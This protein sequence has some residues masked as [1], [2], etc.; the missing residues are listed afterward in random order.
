MMLIKR[1]VTR[2]QKNFPATAIDNNAKMEN[3][4][5]ANTRSSGIKNNYCGMKSLEKGEH[6]PKKEEIHHSKCGQNLLR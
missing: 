4:T 3:E 5:R 6:K 1:S 2:R